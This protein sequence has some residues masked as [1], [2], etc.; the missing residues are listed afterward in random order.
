MAL[1]GLSTQE[2]LIQEQTASNSIENLYGEYGPTYKWCAKNQYL[3]GHGTCKRC[4]YSYY[5]PAGSVGSTSC[6]KGSVHRK[7]SYGRHLLEEEEG[8]PMEGEGLELI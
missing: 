7:P 2:E 5:S 6:H 3:A 1:I 8:S 4:R